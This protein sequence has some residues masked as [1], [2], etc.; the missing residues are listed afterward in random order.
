MSS[1]FRHIALMAQARTGASASYFVLILLAALALATAAVSFWLAAFVW[2]A[3][4]FGGVKAGL[5][6]GG[7][8]V[9][10]ALI[11]ALVAWLVRAR[12]AERARREL[13][14]RR[15]A[16]LVDPGLIPIALQIGQALGWRRLAALAGVG[17]FAA[18]LAREWFGERKDKPDD[19]KDD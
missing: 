5:I 9:L 8:C 16:S 12:N 19:D 3:D 7:V 1:W 2:L 15:R 6:L 11:A 18:G 4:R 10:L 17:V 14:E 13:E